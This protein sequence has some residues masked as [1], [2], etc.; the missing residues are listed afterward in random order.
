MLNFIKKYHNNILIILV[1]ISLIT[2]IA[3]LAINTGYET[4]QPSFRNITFNGTYF[5]GEEE[6]EYSVDA[7]YKENHH[8]KLVFN[9][10][11]DNIAED[12]HCI[13]MPIINSWTQVKVDSKVVASNLDYKENN[14]TNT[15]GYTILYIH[16]KDFNPNS[17]FE[18]TIENPYNQFRSYNPYVLFFRNI[19]SG[20]E[21]SLYPK[22]LS[23]NLFVILLS[24]AIIGC[25]ILFLIY[26]LLA[27]KTE[28]L[29]LISIALVAFFGGLFIL[30][31][32]IYVYMPLFINNPILAMFLDEITTVLFVISMGIMIKEYLKHK[33]TIILMDIAIILSTIS[34]IAIVLLQ[35]LSVGDIISC[36]LVLYPAIVFTAIGG[37]I[38]IFY[39]AIRYKE[40]RT[41]I[42]TITFIPCLIGLIVEVMNEIL[43][44]APSLFI[45]RTSVIIT[46]IMQLI[47]IGIL[48]NEKYKERLRV[49]K[50]QKEL[51]ESKMNIMVSQIQPHF[52]Y[53]ALTSI[54]M[55]CEKD[56]KYAKQETIEFANYLRT[57]MNSLTQ[58]N[59]VIFKDE[60]KHLKTY[61]SL[62]QMRFGDDL[63][64]IYDIGPDSFFIPSL[65][66]QP[67]VEN[68]IKHG[69]GMKEDLGT[70][71][72]STK[73]TDTKYIITIEDDGVGFD[74]DNYLND[75]KNHVGMNNV[76]DRIKSIVNGE[77]I[78]KSTI[79]KGTTSTIVIPK[80]EAN[81]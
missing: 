58:K 36:R 27:N 38:C 20:E 18:I 66:V 60:L 7:I 46:L 37:M 32:C 81:K 61:I 2:L 35:L 45:S 22:I 78:I 50:I 68:A 12:D 11:F 31:D 33:A 76:K 23:D 4:K 6:L 19:I 43:K 15:P 77:V 59:P 67:L 55:L 62:E 26:S 14:K 9:G 65:S 64:V 72:I 40:K 3:F 39:E 53:N 21:N 34:T 13:S 24:L 73:E 28:R 80:E 29:S 8:H 16:S 70:V 30:S 75:G 41:I 5:D 42:I 79:G 10:K 74:V 71:K 1:V 52:L 56:P 44:F 48:I 51:L 49:E 57:N 63:K 69:I 17:V 54:A 25:A 47:T